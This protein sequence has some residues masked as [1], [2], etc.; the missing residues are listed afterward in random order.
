M[1]VD[2]IQY[3]K[4]LAAGKRVVDIGACATGVQA[5]PAF[6]RA[7]SKIS[8]C[9]KSHVC[10]DSD[11]KADVILELDAP[12]LSPLEA[13]LAGCEI[14]L[15]M[16]VL[17]HL[18]NPGRVCDAIAAAVRRGAT[19]FVTIPRASSAQLFLESR[20]FG[21]WW[22]RSTGH[23]YSFG[24]FHADNFM[25]KNFPGLRVTRFR[26]LGQYCRIWP[27]L[28]LA[29]LGRGISHGFLIERSGE[30]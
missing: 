15:C 21:P 29:T 20:G 22:T 30:G 3:A 28:W 8:S 18:R 6:F 16:E 12:D 13:A 2:R 27:L 11:P 10:V 1:M 14:V 26:C 4:K 25:R 24:A 9:C 23:L 7:L 19:A 5:M 17:E